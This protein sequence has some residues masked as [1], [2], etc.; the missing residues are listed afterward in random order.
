VNSG[1]F[2]AYKNIRDTDE[3]LIQYLLKRAK[4]EEPHAVVVTGHSLGGA[5]ANCLAAELVLEYASEID[6]ALVTFGSPRVFPLE[7]FAART[8]ASSI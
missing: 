3:G 6:V 5:M 8:K 4:Q 2:E 7:V 1:F